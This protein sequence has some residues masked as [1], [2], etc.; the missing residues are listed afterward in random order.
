MYIMLLWISWT[1][2]MNL[3]EFYRNHNFL[4]FITWNLLW[5]KISYLISYVSLCH[6][7]KRKIIQFMILISR[8]LI[9][10]I[11]LWI[12]IIFSLFLF[13]I[14]QKKR[15]TYPNKPWYAT[16]HLENLWLELCISSLLRSCLQLRIYLNLLW[17]WWFES[18]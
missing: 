16:W 1:M 7:L 11:F 3:N 12:K 6:L 18:K 5:I 2:K 9:L 8:Y 10:E 13:A 15:E 4:R 17:F 14:Y